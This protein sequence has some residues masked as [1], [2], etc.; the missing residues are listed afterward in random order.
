MTNSDLLIAF[1]FEPYTYS[2]INAVKETK[3]Q[4]TTSS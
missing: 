2:V 3:Q 4:E 1:S